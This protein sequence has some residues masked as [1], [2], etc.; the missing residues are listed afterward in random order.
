MDQVMKELDWENFDDGGKVHQVFSI[1]GT[2][3]GKTMETA[4]EEDSE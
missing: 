3:W 2:P 1:D 4:G